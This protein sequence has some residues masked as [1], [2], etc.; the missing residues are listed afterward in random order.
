MSLFRA[1]DDDSVVIV[2]AMDS[3]YLKHA[4]PLSSFLHQIRTLK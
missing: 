4:E 2:I 1:S 3:W